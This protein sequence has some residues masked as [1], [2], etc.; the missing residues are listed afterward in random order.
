M[1]TMKQANTREGFAMG[2]SSRW[3]LVGMSLA[4][5]LLAACADGQV[6]GITSEDVP[7]KVEKNEA[8]GLSR[9]T[10][11]TKAADRLGIATAAVAEGPSASRTVVPYSAIVYDKTGATWAYTN[12]EGLVYLRAA[13][14]VDR[15]AEDV[16]ILTAGPPVGTAVVTTGASLLWGVETGVG[17]GH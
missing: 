1:N 15:I 14:T 16:A 7:V 2:R 3:L 11:S 12:P 5:S 9:L 8:S 10:L 17:G 13:I 4:V 6:A